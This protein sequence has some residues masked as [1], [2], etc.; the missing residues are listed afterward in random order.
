MP[1]YIDNGDSQI[2]QSQSQIQSQS[3]RRR[4]IS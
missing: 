3:H 1:I 2:D 4:G